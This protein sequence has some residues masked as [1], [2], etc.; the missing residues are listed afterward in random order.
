MKVYS[1]RTCK[2]KKK[3]KISEI[4]D[5]IPEE[6]IGFGDDWVKEFLKKIPWNIF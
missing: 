4:S 1:D 5:E 3:H 2:I 6:N